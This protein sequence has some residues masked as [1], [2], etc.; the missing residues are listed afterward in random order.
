MPSQW[1]QLPSGYYPRSVAVSNGAIL[2]TC[3]VA[4]PFQQVVRVDFA[5][6]VATAPATLGIYKNS[7]DNNAALLASPSGEVIFMAM[8]DGTVV[9]YEATSDTFVA[10][11]KDLTSLGGAYASLADDVFVVERTCWTALW[12]LW[13]SST[14]PPAPP[15]GWLQ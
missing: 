10:S 11:R 2:V 8:P 9:L 13:G 1:I 5:N 3:R 4:G 12:Y 6:R 14:P 15:Q 7:I